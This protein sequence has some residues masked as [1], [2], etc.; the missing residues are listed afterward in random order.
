MRHN[1]MTKVKCRI[2]DYIIIANLH[3]YDS[4][5]V[6]LRTTT[7]ERKITS[8]QKYIVTRNYTLSPSIF[9]SILFPR[10]A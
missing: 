4:V 2:N 3:L 5:I 7:T 10:C 8:I 1:G 6:T 9:G